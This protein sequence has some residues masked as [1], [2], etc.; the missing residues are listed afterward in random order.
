MTSMWSVGAVEDITDDSAMIRRTA[1][2]TVHPFDDPTADWMLARVRQELPLYLLHVA[3]HSESMPPGLREALHDERPCDGLIFSQYG[4]PELRQKLEGWLPHDEGWRPES[5]PL[6]SVS[7]SGTGAAIFDI[8]RMLKAG[9]QEPSAILLPRPGW[10]YELSVRDT[11][12]QPVGYEVPVESP[13]GP[14]IAHLHEA[15]LRCRQEG[16]A[17]AGI[18]VNPQHNPWG[19]NWTPEFLDAVADLS[20]TER[21]PVLVD[22][23]FFGVTAQEVEPTSAVRVMD[24]LI[25]QDLLVSVR[26]LSKQFACSG[27]ALGAV[28]GSPK[29]VSEYSGRWRCTREPTANFRAQAAMASWLGGQESTQFAWQRRRDTTRNA[30]LLRQSLSEVGLALIHHGGAPFALLRPPRH[31]SAAE[32]R[33]RIVEDSGVLLGMDRDARGQEFFKI[34]LGRSSQVFEPAVRA[35]C[36]SVAMLWSD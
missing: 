3:D 5:A 25:A 18:I 22:N 4:L 31:G 23:A 11:G 9:K 7:W 10:G 24:R 14:D 8:L 2:D 32:L 34:W 6:V 16:L 1:V 29:L 33:K 17:V 30:W 12:F 19:G 35:L 28:A 36:G 27:W 13:Q 21:A 26:S 15:L 20:E